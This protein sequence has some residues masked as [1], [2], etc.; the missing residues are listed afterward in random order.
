MRMRA[1][2]PNGSD[3]VLQPNDVVSETVHAIDTAN[4]ELRR[5]NLEVKSSP[6]V[7]KRGRFYRLTLAL[8]DLQQPR[9]SLSRDQGMQITLGLVRVPGLERQARRLRHRDGL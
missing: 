6:S 7:T 9:D 3:V 2:E 1:Q 8:Q 4:D 5:L